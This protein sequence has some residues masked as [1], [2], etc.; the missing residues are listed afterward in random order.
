MHRVH[1]TVQGEG[2]QRDR[3]A[4]HP[5]RTQK[6]R[7]DQ[8]SSSQKGTGWGGTSGSFDGS[9]SAAARSTP[10]AL[11]TFDTAGGCCSDPCCESALS[12]PAS[13]VTGA[14]VVADRGGRG[15]LLSPTPSAKLK[16]RHPHE[17]RSREPVLTR[18]RAHDRGSGGRGRGRSSTP[19]WGAAPGRGLG[20]I[21]TPTSGKGTGGRLRQAVEPAKY[22]GV[23][24]DKKS[25]SALLRRYPISPALP[26]VWCDHMTWVL[27]HLSPNGPRPQPAWV[28][29]PATS[30]SS[31]NQTPTGFGSNTVWLC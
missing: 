15:V 5:S 21:A 17:P 16:G 20:P 24:L 25:Q 8:Q 28:L 12:P 10:T 26:N 3:P 2:R 19:T 18:T 11:R 6:H 13:T 29:C 27:L 7:Q 22:V 14:H 1:G 31:N 30:L 9:K 4:G 23:F